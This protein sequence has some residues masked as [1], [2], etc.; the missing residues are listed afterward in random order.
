MLNFGKKNKLNQMD[1]LKEA[2]IE[3]LLNTEGQQ[4]IA[5][6]VKRLSNEEPSMAWRAQL[7]A[8]LLAEAQATRKVERRRAWIFRPAAGL[9]MAGA[10]A[11]VFISTQDN[12]TPVQSSSS[13]FEEQIV[14]AH[15]AAEQSVLLT[16]T[17]VAAHTSN[18]G[19]T[20]TSTIDWQETDL[21]A[22]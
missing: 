13:S 15:Y 22:F 12:G 1:P 8:Q 21:G 3:E 4:F 2:R 5:Q 17:S 14:N 11:M 7:N 20:N 18:G 6:G 9:A 10:L 19:S 16:G